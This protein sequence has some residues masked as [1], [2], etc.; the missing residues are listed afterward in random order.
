MFMTDK[1]K[2]Q[3]KAVMARERA[4]IIMEVHSGILTATD[5]A[6]KLGVSRKTYYKWE[7]RGL[8]ALMDGLTDHP[9]G[10]SDAPL[11]TQHEAE[12]ERELAE[13]KKRNENLEKQLGL[14][15]LVHELEMDMHQERTKKK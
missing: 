4:R 9:S 2:K 1:N 3:K 10:R 5:A 15:T 13:M 8:A 12:L 7:K 11:S 6:R 14:K